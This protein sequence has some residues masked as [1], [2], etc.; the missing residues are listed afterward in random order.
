MLDQILEIYGVRCPKRAQAD[1]LTGR[2][3]NLT[4][5]TLVAY[6]DCDVQRMVLR[7]DR[8]EDVA[9]RGNIR[10]LETKTLHE[11]RSWMWAD[12]II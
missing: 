9:C 10:C 6:L 5:S 4:D 3:L 2:G 11:C 7:A 1:P 12:Y 8:R